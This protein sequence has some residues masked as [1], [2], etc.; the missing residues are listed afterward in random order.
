M[1]ATLYRYFPDKTNLLAAIGRETLGRLAAEFEATVASTDDR[2]GRLFRCP[3]QFVQFGLE[4]P[5]HFMTFFFGPR[6]RSGVRVGECISEVGRPLFDRMAQI[7]SDAL[8]QAGVFAR[9]LQLDSHTWWAAM[10]GLKQVLI[11][12]ENQAQMPERGDVADRLIEALWAGLTTAAAMG[13]R[14]RRAT[15]NAV[16]PRGK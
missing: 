5:P 2:R 8:R 12:E 1:H 7:Y 6:G 9:D 14:P 11:T 3:R 13:C 16:R 10:F 15:R 4:H